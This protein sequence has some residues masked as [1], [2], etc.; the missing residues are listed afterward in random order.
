MCFVL[1]LILGVLAISN[2][3]LLFSN[4]LQCASALIL[5]FIYLLILSSSSIF[6]Y[7]HHFSH[8]HGKSYVFCFSGAICICKLDNQAIGQFIY[9]ITY[10]VLD[11]AVLVLSVAVTTKIR[12]HIAFQIFF[13][14]WFHYQTMLPCSFQVFTQ[15]YY[16]ISM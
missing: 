9:V 6:N 7:R 1:G 3:P 12:I 11:L 10:P 2:A 4:A 5:V 13:F 8:C 15:L 14:I 16:F